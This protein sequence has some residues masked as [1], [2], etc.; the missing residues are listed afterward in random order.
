MDF[1]FD[2]Y[3]ENI[4]VF[5]ELLKALDAGKKVYCLGKTYHPI[6]Y[7]KIIEFEGDI[8]IGFFID[9]KISTISFG[10]GVPKKYSKNDLYTPVNLEIRTI[11]SGGGEF[12]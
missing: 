3:I 1:D 4:K 7:F 2:Y 5:N 11:E 6:V 12:A 9:G 8:A 10:V